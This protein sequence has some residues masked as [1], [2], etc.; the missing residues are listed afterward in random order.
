MLTFVYMFEFYLEASFSERFV[1]VKDDVY[2]WCIVN[3][4]FVAF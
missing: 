2:E 1:G 4:H 3:D